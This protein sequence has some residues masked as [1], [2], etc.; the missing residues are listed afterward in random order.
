MAAAAWY[1]RFP[2]Y[3]VGTGA[4]LFVV[5]DWLIFSRFGSFDLGVLPDLLIWPFYYV[6]QV[7]DRDRNR[8]MS[9]RRAAGSGDGLLAL[10]A[11]NQVTGGSL[12]F[13]IF[14]ADGF[15]RPGFFFGRFL[16]FFVD[17]SCSSGRQML[18]ALG[19][20]PTMPHA[21]RNCVP[22]IWKGP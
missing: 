10:W 15:S 11:G 22:E 1:S 12:S 9:A 17:S 18:F 8:A 13:D 5:S 14:A 19:K 16:G 4:V 7:N 2:R 6:G 20:R 3:R 21:R